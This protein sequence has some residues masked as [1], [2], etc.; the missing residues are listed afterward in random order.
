MK[1]WSI[2]RILATGCIICLG[3]MMSGCSKDS[4]KEPAEVSA[5]AETETQTEEQPEEA[6]EGE[7]E[8]T[9][10][11]DLDPETLENIK[12]NV[13]IQ[14]NNTLVEMMD[15]IDNYFLAV[16]YAEEFSLIEGGK[17]YQYGLV[18]I[19]QDI[20]GDAVLVSAYE[21][22]WDEMDSI[23]N[24]IAEPMQTLADTFYDLRNNND[25]ADNQ[26]AKA[27]EYHAVIMEHAD[28]FYGMANEFV[29]ALDAVADERV[30]EEEAQMLE[31]GE[32]IIYNS[33]H[34]ITLLR[35]IIDEC[36]NQGVSD[37]NL[38][39]LDTAPI[40]AL[41]E[42]M[43]ACVDAYNAAC[44]DNDQL[45]KESLSN[46]APFD[47]LLDSAAQ[48]VE[49]MIGQA[50]SG[51]PVTDIDLSPLG[52]LGHVYEVLSQCVDRYNSVFAE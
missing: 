45:V 17:P 1:M 28:N 13:Y 33:S 32:L 3:M 19:D 16:N 34:V 10:L 49:W 18:G 23:V 14:F 24:E 30:A 27:K 21:P 46:S 6:A 26:Y 39:D 51:N 42:E 50:E 43:I 25:Y 9:G 36:E 37:E 4:G 15:N 22:K 40:R 2:K 31:D 8:E 11:E 29:S 35:N 38:N 5:E 41:H 7:E 47:G 12:Y 48:S 44:A 52:S 20:L